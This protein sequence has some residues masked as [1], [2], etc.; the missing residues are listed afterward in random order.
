MRSRTNRARKFW[1]CFHGTVVEHKENA[2]QVAGGCCETTVGKGNRGVANLL[3]RNEKCGSTEAGPFESHSQILRN[4][5]RSHP[6]LDRDG[7]YAKRAIGPIPPKAGRNE[8]T[9]SDAT[10]SN[11]R[12]SKPNAP[13]MLG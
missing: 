2:C 1:N 6:Y 9:P 8:E 3:E 10:D 5:S 13:F 4:L 7:I 11:P 12:H